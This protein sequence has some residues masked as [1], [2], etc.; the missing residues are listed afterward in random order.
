MRQYFEDEEPEEEVELSRDTEVTLSPGALLGIFF[1]LVL[2]CGLCFGL[3]YWVGHRGSGPAQ[4]AAA[5]PASQTP[6][7]DAEPLQASGSV[8]KPSA[9]AQVPAATPNQPGDG[10]QAAPGAAVA[11][12]ANPQ[13]NPAPP[14]ESTPPPSAPAS[15]PPTQPQEQ[16]PV[17][18][19]PQ[20][21]ARPAY[22]SAASAP[23]PAGT[24]YAP[25]VHTSSPGTGQLMV[26]IAAVSHEEDADVLV[27]ALRRHGYSAI[28]RHD[29]NDG[30][31]HVRI[32]P[33]ATREDANRMARRL[34]DDGYNAMIQP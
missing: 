30:L 16:S 24:G 12:P 34:L 21:P 14:S 28:A 31:I 23:Q 25:N 4:T 9:D 29:P 22:S 11:N 20:S 18:P 2:I 32:G 1:G 6:A 27:N 19:Q 26:Q 17:R 7:P 13:P 15:A 5:Q 8:P 33:F 3:G 10:S